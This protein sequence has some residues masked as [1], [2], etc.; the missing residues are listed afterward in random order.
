VLVAAGWL[1]WTT[2]GWN[3]DAIA[4]A[5]WLT[6]SHALVL[7][8]CAAIG[9]V[10]SAWQATSRS[11]LVVLVG[12]WFALWIVLPRVLPAA[13]TA[14]YPVPAR[15][16][17][18]AEVEARVKEL[19]DSHDPSDPVFARFR[20]ETLARYGVA[21]VEDLPVNYGGLVMQEG[22]R[23]T[24]E[25]FRE[26]QGQLLAVYRRQS[27]LIEA[28]GVISPYLA[29]RSISM[30]LAGADLA[31]LYEFDRQAETFRYTLIQALN[32][33]HVTQ[34]SAA[35]DRYGEVTDGAPTRQ[36]ID[37]SHFDALPRFDYRVP[38]AAW[39]LAQHPVSAA[40]GLLGA[41]LAVVALAVTAARRPRY[42]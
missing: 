19:G 11:A 39:A 37:T 16:A 12:L 32:D 30:A 36:R 20:A 4:R 24:A 15:A 38:G 3:A 8:T 22:E 27:A 17:F 26:H 9:I 1:A 40:A 29:M 2:G 18:D 35:A 34:V 5:V 28:A 13:A 14:L 21:R 6:G 42:W 41:C 10:V 7:G 25:A 31:H 23:H 33:L